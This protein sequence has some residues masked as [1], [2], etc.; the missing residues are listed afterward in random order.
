MIFDQD[1][2]DLINGLG[3]VEYENERNLG[4][5]CEEVMEPQRL[6]KYQHGL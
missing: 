1:L 6:K 2:S 4:R 5:I 3:F